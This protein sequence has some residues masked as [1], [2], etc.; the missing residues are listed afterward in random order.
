RV[1]GSFGIINHLAVSGLKSSKSSLFRQL[2]RFTS[3]AKYFPNLPLPTSIGREVNPSSVMGPA[4]VHIV[5]LV[6]RQGTRQSTFRFHHED[7]VVLAERR[8]KGDA[9][10]IRRPSRW[11]YR[12]RIPQIG[13]LDQIR[14]VSVAGP[15]F[16]RS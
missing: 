3:F 8:V 9:L 7:R 14:T 10:A 11:S 15:D 4:G 5:R 16:E 6:S 13:Q 1:R 12:C 2:K